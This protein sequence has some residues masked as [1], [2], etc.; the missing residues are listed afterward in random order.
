[1]TDPYL[2]P[3]TGVLKNKVNA[4]TQTDLDNAESVLVRIRLF[5]TPS[6]RLP[7]TSD[8]VE[9]Q[10]I[11]QHLFQDIY[12]WAG[13]YRKMDMSKGGDSFL[14]WQSI[15]SGLAYLTEELK[16]DNWLQQMERNKFVKRLAYHYGELNYVHPFR[17]G[18]GRTQR[19]FWSRI[20][21]RANHFINWPTLNATEINQASHEARIGTHNQLETMFEK[22]VTP[23]PDKLTNKAFLKDITTAADTQHWSKTKKPHKPKQQTKTPNPTTPNNHRRR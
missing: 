18:N 8:A 1:M 2:D 10:A 20:A 17:E 5:E 14:S 9:L 12:D 19:L 23:K 21:D 6:T 4:H 7:K 15:D 16:N 11:H 22:A 13:T 3:E